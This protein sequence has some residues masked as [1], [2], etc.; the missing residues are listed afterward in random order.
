[1]RESFSLADLP[2]R[3]KPDPR[4]ESRIDPM[5]SGSIDPVPPA[6]P[7]QEEDLPRANS[8][9]RNVRGPAQEPAAAFPGS[10]ATKLKK[11]AAAIS[12]APLS[13]SVL[14][15]IP[16]SRNQPKRAG[17]SAPAKTAREK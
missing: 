15:S 9:K 7:P 17:V 1:M 14:M 13:K 11:E 8:P 4:R 12:A 3:A 5:R 6:R 10:G 16:K 2:E